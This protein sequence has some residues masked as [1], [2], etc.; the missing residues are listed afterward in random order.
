VPTLFAFQDKVK[1]YTLAVAICIFALVA[2]V[3]VIWK[4][5]LVR[6]WL[7]LFANILPGKLKTR[8]LGFLERG[9][10]SFSQLKNFRTLL[11][12]SMFTIL[13]IVLSALTNFLL[14]RAAGLDLGFYQALVLLLMI[15]VG[16]QP[17]SVPGK[18][19]IFEYMVLVGLGFFSIDRSEA[20]GYAIVLHVVSYLPKIILGF[21]FMA[22][23]NMSIKKAGEEIDSLNIAPGEGTGPA[24]AEPGQPANESV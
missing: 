3:L 5:D 6:K 9:M 2:L 17:P 24:N 23:L 15:Q 14:F 20:M 21:I 16:T 13:I 19:G 8:V 7:Y 1:G 4:R 12:L 18:V 11:T 10:E 22:S